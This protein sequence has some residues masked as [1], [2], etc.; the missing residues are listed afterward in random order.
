MAAQSQGEP[1][2]MIEKPRHLGREYAAAFQDR[3]VVEA[4]RYRPPYA[5]EVFAILAGLI[6]DGP[7]RVLDVGC[8]TGNIARYLVTRVAWLDA[9]DAS[10]HMIE[11]GKRLAHGDDPRLRWLH[12]RVEDV[13]LDGP[14]GLVA[15]GESLHWMDWT[16]VLPRFREVLA[17][18]GYLAVVGQE[19][20]PDPWSALG[21][22]VER[23]RTDGGYQP[24]DMLGEL[25]RHGLFQKE[26]EARTAPVRVVQLIDDYVE[27]YHARSGFAR[28]RM[29]A[30]RAAS[31]DTEAREFLRG[32]H[33][34]GTVT[35]E[36]VSSVVWGLPGG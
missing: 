35:L 23:Y 15:A 33:G 36:V 29:G 8:G 1:A 4:Y 5:A 2:G 20:T 22:L 11:E 24:Y 18:G 30:A 34:D 27:S 17:P 31:F 21:G 32:A 12:G 3:G 14:Y 7:R 28:E 16:I 13:A 10:R 9:V 26:S 19:I 25:E 6:G